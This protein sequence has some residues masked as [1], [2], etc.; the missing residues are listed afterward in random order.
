MI[1]S[2]S[3]DFYVLD[4]F[5]V[6]RNSTGLTDKELGYEIDKIATQTYNDHYHEMQRLGYNETDLSL[7]VQGRNLVVV[8]PTGKTVNVVPL[9]KMNSNRNYYTFLI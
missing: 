1:K 9:A 3:G 7:L 4:D 2:Q 6:I 5:N 8:D